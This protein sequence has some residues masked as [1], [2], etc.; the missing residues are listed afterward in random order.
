MG[1]SNEVPQR[2]DAEHSRLVHRPR[3][4]AQGNVYISGTAN[5][6]GTWARSDRSPREW[7]NRRLRELAREGCLVDAVATAEGATHKALVSAAYDIVWPIVFTRLTRRVE[8]RRGHLRC[9]AGIGYLTDECLDRFHDDVEAVVDDLLAHTRQPVANLE[10][11]IATR[12]TAATVDGHRRRRGQRGALQRPRLP[13]W[14]A[15]LLG[16]DGWLMTLATQILVWVGVSGTA[17]HETWPIE[18]W[19]QERAAYTRDWL[20]SDPGTVAGEVETVLAAMRERSDWYASYVERPLGRKQAPVAAM[21]MEDGTGQSATPL[22]L[23]DPDG[24]VEAEMRA[25]AAE[26]VGRIG[27]RLDRGEDPREVVAGVIRTIFGG[28]LTATLNRSPHECGEPL[29]G[30]TGALADPATLNR[31]I[32]TVRTIIGDSTAEGGRTR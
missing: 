19:A 20:G 4:S 3:N 12:L 22:S 28:A 29:G 31:I 8:Q 7:G 17:G 15:E 10:A 11:W 24:Q 21:P 13:A 18:A 6:G 2:L 30:V 14:L 23:G 9:A 1:V 25:R 16:N 5:G 27:R 26:A 32:A